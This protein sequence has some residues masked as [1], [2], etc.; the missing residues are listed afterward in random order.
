M[1]SGNGAG[2]STSVNCEA[3]DIVQAE[4]VRSQSRERIAE[5]ERTARIRAATLQ[6]AGALAVAYVQYKF[7]KE[8]LELQ[9]EIWETQKR[10]AEMYHDMWYD[11]YRPAE[12]SFLKYAIE[13]GPYI[14]KFTAAESRAVIH[15]RREF[16]KA[17]EKMRRCI[18]PRCVGELCYNNKLLA[19][20]EARTAVAAVDRGYRAEE[21]RKDQ[22]DLQWE[23]LM[24]GMLQL[25][26]G[27]AS[28]AGNLLSNASATAA[29][30]ANINPYGGFAAAMG[31]IMSTYA[32][33]TTDRVPYSGYGINSSGNPITG[34]TQGYSY[35]YTDAYNYNF[36][37]NNEVEIGYQD[38][39]IRTDGM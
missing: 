19:V 13:K 6:A 12:L 1:G 21:A 14:P 3:A 31:N 20:E 38:F 5:A 9:R 35:D 30:A 36:E 8:K 37:T 7:E 32:N 18:D 29:N 17:R 4:Q 22:K 2:Q 33:V 24:Q 26:R 23:V 10:W 39:S 34:S 16:S 25:G 15:V 27:L 11:N 28:N